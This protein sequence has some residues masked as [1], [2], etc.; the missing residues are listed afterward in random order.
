MAKKISGEQCFLTH[1]KLF[2][3]K[4]HN[5]HTK[6]N[7]KVKIKEY[8]NSAVHTSVGPINVNELAQKSIKQH[9]LV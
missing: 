5:I 4:Q 2:V 9:T 3:N 7:I 8:L 1:K 6:L